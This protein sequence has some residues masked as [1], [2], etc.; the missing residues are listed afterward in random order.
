ME[1]IIRGIDTLNEKVGLYSSLLMPPLVAVVIYEVFVRYVF[2]APT[3][4]GF[5][6][7]TFLYG[8]NYMLAL[9]DAMRTNTHV[10]IDIFE[11][12]LAA[13]NRVILR[14][15]TSVCMFIPAM[16]FMAFGSIKY[17]FTSWMIW[18]HASSSWGPAIYPYKTFMAVGFVLFFLAGIAKLL[19]DIRSLK[20]FN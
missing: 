1:T 20:S 17:A 12:R 3:S 13:K 18:E 9:G 14:I 7:T 8:I 11:S 6:L 16:G 10:S 15:I 5:E 2:R 4:W 19:Q